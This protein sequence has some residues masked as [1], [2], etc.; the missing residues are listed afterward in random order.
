M[1][2]NTS[3]KFRRFKKN[4]YHTCLTSCL[5]TSGAPTGDVI[6]K[7]CIFDIQEVMKQTRPAQRRTDFVV[8][9]NLS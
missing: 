4:P 8:I 2:V 9:Q 5:T 1:S 7:F 3:V 6:V